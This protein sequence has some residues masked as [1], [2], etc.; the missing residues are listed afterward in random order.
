V[1]LI[2]VTIYPATQRCVLLDVLNILRDKT[3]GF[4]VVNV[5]L[6]EDSLLVCK[7]WM[8]VLKGKNKK[9]LYVMNA[10]HMNSAGC[11]HRPT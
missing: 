8:R 4:D 3:G 2:T 7:L 11:C 1:R 9:L 5:L 10:Q 6:T